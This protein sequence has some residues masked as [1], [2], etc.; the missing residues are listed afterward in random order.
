MGLKHLLNYSHEGKPNI[1]EPFICL[2]IN[3][4]DFG[5]LRGKLT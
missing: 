2:N 4:L 5:V 1:K 3:G